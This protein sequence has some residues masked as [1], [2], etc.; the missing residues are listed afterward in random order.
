VHQTS[1]ASTDPVTL[2]PP[3]L[4]LLLLLL[5]L[6]FHRPSETQKTSV[7][8][9]DNTPRWCETF[10]FVMISAGS[11]LTLSVMN[12]TGILDATLSLKMSKVSGVTC[13]VTC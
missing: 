1:Q 5:L 7:K 12:K 9:N 6:R 13:Y 2:L 3:L 11:M 4:L 10:D 8:F